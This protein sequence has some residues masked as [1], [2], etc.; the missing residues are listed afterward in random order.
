MAAP[1]LSVLQLRSKRLLAGCAEPADCV[2]SMTAGFDG[3]HQSRA[4]HCCEF[5]HAYGICV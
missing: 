1:V 2:L 3:C 5:T 4:G